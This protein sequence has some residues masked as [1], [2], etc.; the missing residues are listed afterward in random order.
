MNP[1]K[2]T[3]NLHFIYKFKSRR[4]VNSL[5]VIET[6]HVM[7]CLKTIAVCPENHRKHINDFGRQKVV[8]LNVK[9]GGTHSNPRVN[10][11]AFFIEI[12]C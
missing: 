9:R 11:C 5:P 8:V 6:N 12:V 1:T 7:R 3:N 4:L 2:T 10:E